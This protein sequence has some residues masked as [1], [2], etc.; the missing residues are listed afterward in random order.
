MIF[1]L[2]TATSEERNKM[3]PKYAGAIV[4]DTDLKHALVWTGD[5]WYLDEMD[6]IFEGDEVFIRWEI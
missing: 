6:L 2:F 3:K 5:Y 1:K 4:Y